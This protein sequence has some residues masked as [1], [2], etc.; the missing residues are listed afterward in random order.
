M[1]YRIMGRAHA[2]ALRARARVEE[3]AGQGTVEYVALI[4][5]V[6][7]LFATVVVA[8]GGVK[9]KGIADAVTERIKSTIEGVGAKR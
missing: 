7:G 3:S 5:L 4:L 8:A 6:A 1:G 2:T 9:G